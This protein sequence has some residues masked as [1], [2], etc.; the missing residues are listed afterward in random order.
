[1]NESAGAAAKA[2][3]GPA[4]APPAA[5]TMTDTK[6]KVKK[7]SRGPL[8][9]G[10]GGYYRD[11][12]FNIVGVLEYEDNEGWRWVEYYVKFEDG[13]S[14][15]LEYDDDRY[16]LLFDLDLDEDYWKPKVG[17]TGKLKLPNGDKFKV[18]E[19]GK[20]KITYLWGQIPFSATP[21]VKIRY[22]DG[23]HPKK[24]KI[25]YSV[26]YTKKETEAFRGK[27]VKVKNKGGI[28]YVSD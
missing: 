2:P 19:K 1:M 28:V 3:R 22:I 11:D 9:V 8:E 7:E 13:R 21:N 18:T 12:P 14:G 23:R 26:E 27:R 25:R 5:P 16:N 6:V 24:K 20:S 17:W 4:S 15:W 10:M